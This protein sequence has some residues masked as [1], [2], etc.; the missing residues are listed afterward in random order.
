MVVCSCGQFT[1]EGTTLCPRCEALHVLGLGMHALENEIRSAYRLLSKAWLPENFQDDPK[2][3]DS[4]EAK[5]KDIQ[6]AFDFLTLTSTDRVQ[7]RRPVYLSANLAAAA[8]VPAPISDAQ[9]FHGDNSVP[10]PAPIPNASPASS[11]LPKTEPQQTP[12]SPWQKF[13]IPIIALA[14]F[15]ALASLFLIWTASSASNPSEDQAVKVNGSEAR[16]KPMNPAVALLAQLLNK[17]DPL[18]ATTAPQNSESTP[19]NSTFN[20]QSPT[21]DANTHATTSEPINGKNTPSATTHAAIRPAQP[22]TT[23][24][25]HIDGVQLTPYITV[26]STREEVLAQQGTPTASTED[27]LIFGKSEIYLRNNTVVGWRIDRIASP[28]H[29]KL[30]PRTPVDPDL[31]FFTVGSTK[32]EVLKVQGTPTAFTE[33]QFEY[34]HSIVYFSNN[35]VV[36]WK[37]DPD[38]VTLWAR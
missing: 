36:R 17:I 2:L 34:D 15:L 24:R 22:A 10:T 21:A 25:N 31:Q 29:V 35:R 4:A 38:S 6:S 16:K 28:L 32:D 37:S 18:P 5:L 7:A 33:D 12:Q 1:E 19:Q 30:W 14:A 27:K 9:S 13:K 8:A 11:T 26:G 23:Q 20:T 3:K